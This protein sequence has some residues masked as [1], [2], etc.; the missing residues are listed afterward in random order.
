G[1]QTIGFLADIALAFP[2]QP[3]S[4]EQGIAETQADAAQDRKSTEPAEFAA[5]V[6]AVGDRKLFYEGAY[7]HPL[8]ECGDERPSG[9]TGVPD[10]PHSLGLVAILERNAAQDQP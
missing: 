3:T 8:R 10:P 5:G 2:D 9:K 4:T 1:D 6:L 7:G